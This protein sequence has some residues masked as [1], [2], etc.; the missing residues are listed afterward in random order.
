MIEQETIH[1]CGERRQ[2]VA[3]AP[4]PRTILTPSITTLRRGVLILKPDVAGRR[5]AGQDMRFIRS[6]ANP[7]GSREAEGWLFEHAHAGGGQTVWSVWRL[8]PIRRESAPS[9]QWKQPRTYRP[10]RSQHTVISTGRSPKLTA[11]WTAGKSRT[12]PVV[13]QLPVGHMVLLARPRL[14]AIFSRI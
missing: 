12:D 13:Q 2:D 10:H 6:A 8:E 9:D 3:V 7:S 5:A 1:P 4:Y 11:V 14:Y